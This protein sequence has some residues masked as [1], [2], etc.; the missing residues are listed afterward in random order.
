MDKED[1]RSPIIR[2]QAQKIE[3]L[4]RVL[5]VTRMLNETL[6]LE[7]Q[8]QLIQDASTELTE[9]EAGAIF[10]RDAK[11]DELFF[12][13]ATGAA[14]E[15][16]K[17]D[18]LKK[19]PVPMEGS[20]AGWVVSNGKSAVVNDVKHDTRHFNKADDATKF[21]T[22]SI[23]AVPLVRRGKIIGAL[24]VLNKKGDRPF[25]DEDVEI[26]TTLAAQAA[27]SIENARLFE[28]S[29]LISEVVHELRTPMTSIIGYAKMINMPGIPEEAKIK[30]AET[31]H[32]EAARL[33]KMVNDFL[34]WARLES[35]R[36]RMEEK[37]VDMRQVIQDTAAI[38]EP[39]AQE[40]GI[41]VVQDLPE[42]TMTV[43]GD[44]ARLKQIL[45]NLASNGVKY[46]KDEG[47][48]NIIARIEGGNLSVA[49]QDTGVGI[50]EDSLDKL[51]Q[52][53]YRVPGTE[54]IVRG[55]GLGLNI[56]K[57]LIEAQGGKMDV[58]STVGEGTTFTITMPLAQN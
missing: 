35:G 26:L 45:V 21:E 47:R 34:E 25:S 33:G 11:T 50:P 2:S 46:N 7:M 20:I 39:Q 55:T 19:I 22:R 53:F 52:R 3:G 29:D 54:H 38:I 8:L 43:I 12:L 23:L 27:V 10:L 15:G 17:G 36:I 14:A 9:T 16:E 49:V 57:S 41:T 28:Q 48:L 18:K 51:F 31:I 5:E 30:F 37:P 42:G 13:S 56:A 32:R 40:H 44:E 1:E 58:E 24:E 6:N 4:L